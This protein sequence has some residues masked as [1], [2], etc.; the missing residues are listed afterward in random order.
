MSTGI[1]PWS[2]LQPPTPTMNIRAAETSRSRMTTDFVA[3]DEAF[4]RFGRSRT[5]SRSSAIHCAT[6]PA[7]RNFAPAGGR[8]AGVVEL[9]DTP[10]LGAGGASRGGSSPSARTSIRLEHGRQPGR[11]RVP[12]R[13]HALEPV[14]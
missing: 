8:P 11:H 1:A 9:V 5:Y 6:Y 14:V 10:A 12:D 3:F 7:E 13:P 4:R 2:L